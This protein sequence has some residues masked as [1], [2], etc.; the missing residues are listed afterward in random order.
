VIVELTEHAS[1]KDVGAFVTAV[2]DLKAIGTRLAIDDVGAGFAGLSRLLDLDPDIIKLDLGITRHIDSD[3]KR[4]ALTS[5]FV[6]FAEEAG[7]LLVA[8][9]VETR[10]EET[11]LRERGVGLAQGYRFAKPMELDALISTVPVGVGS[12]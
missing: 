9:G 1:V 7:I 2:T 3:P 10:E 8:E 4:Q 6:A 12:T 5:A 11:A